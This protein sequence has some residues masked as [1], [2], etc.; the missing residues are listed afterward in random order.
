[1]GLGV[2]LKVQTSGTG[3]LHP[4]GWTRYIKC[5]KFDHNVKRMVPMI[6]FFDGTNISLDFGKQIE[7]AHI[8]GQCSDAPEIL[9]GQNVACKADI[10]GFAW[11]D[12][13]LGTAIRVYWVENGTWYYIEGKVST[14]TFTH[15]PANE[16]WWNFNMDL[17]GASL[18]KTGA[19]NT[20]KQPGN[21]TDAP[22]IP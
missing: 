15:D 3:A 19:A 21:P 12:W 5:E 17:Q 4:A 22:F 7:A 6:N 11:R 13:T 9:D 16:S 2:C 10:E 14:C 18:D 8:I 20:G 1:M